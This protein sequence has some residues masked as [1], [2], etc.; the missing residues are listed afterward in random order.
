[1]LLILLP[2]ARFLGA[3]SEAIA[4]NGFGPMPV[5]LL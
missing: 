2:F 4:A 3:R 5:E 1:M